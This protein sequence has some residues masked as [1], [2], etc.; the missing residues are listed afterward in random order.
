MRREVS[1]MIRCV[2]F[3]QCTVVGSSLLPPSSIFV[4]LVQTLLPTAHRLRFPS[5]AHR[6][7]WISSKSAYHLD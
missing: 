6:A 2:I 5:T 7:A 3:S 4:D 1:V